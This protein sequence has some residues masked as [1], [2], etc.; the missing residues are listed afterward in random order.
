MSERSLSQLCNNNAQHSSHA[1][2]F[3]TVVVSSWRA[4]SASVRV[5]R[6]LAES[7]GDRL[8]EGT[9]PS[10]PD[11]ESILLQDDQNSSNTR[12]RPST[13]DE[14]G[15]KP[16]SLYSSRPGFQQPDLRDVNFGHIELLSPWFPRVDPEHDRAKGCWSW[17]IWHSRRDIVLWTAFAISFSVLIANVVIVAVLGSKHGISSNRGLIKLYEGDCERVKYMGI[18]AHVGINILSTLLLGNSNLCMQLLVAPTRDEIDAAH[19][20]KVWLDIGIQSW[21]NLTNIKPSRMWIWVILLIS[22]IPLHF[23]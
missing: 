19:R 2:V 6:P 21:R 11:E 23:M 1:D 22:S 14:L 7:S 8:N 17:R 9:I 20:R 12:P 15:L 18:G 5:T 3:P 4:S 16:P 10:E 13:E